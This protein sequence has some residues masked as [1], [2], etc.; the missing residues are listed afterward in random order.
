M[1]IVHRKYL[2]IY[3][4]EQNIIAKNSSKSHRKFDIK[5]CCPAVE[6]PTFSSKGS[7]KYNLFIHIRFEV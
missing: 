7:Y 2:N 6:L 4:V 3:D 1:N 5:E